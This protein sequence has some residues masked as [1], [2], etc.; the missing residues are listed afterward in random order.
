MQ[1]FRKYPVAHPLPERAELVELA[2]IVGGG[3]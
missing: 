3:S 2:P 1:L